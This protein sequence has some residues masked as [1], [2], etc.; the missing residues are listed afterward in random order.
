V[1]LSESLGRVEIGGVHLFA[2]DK[3]LHF[4]AGMLV[5]LFVGVVT[6]PYV[7]LL[8]AAIIGAAKEAYD[9]KTGLGTAEWLDFVATVVGG[10]VGACWLILFW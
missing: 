10:S 4:A 6:T 5:A 2:Q 1:T 8:A 3:Q 9:Y 7:G